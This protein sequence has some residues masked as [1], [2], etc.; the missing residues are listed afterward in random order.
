MSRPKSL[1]IYDQIKDLRALS[2]ELVRLLDAPDFQKLLDLAEDSTLFGDLGFECQT[3]AHR[4]EAKVLRSAIDL[5]YQIERTV[6]VRRLNPS[7]SRRS[8]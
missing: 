5:I 6:R 3:C 8:A 1:T 4:E 2:D 7:R